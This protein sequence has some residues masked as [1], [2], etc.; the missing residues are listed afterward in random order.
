MKLWYGFGSE[1][2]MRLRMIGKFKEIGDA[3]EAM[4][5]IDEITDLVNKEVDSGEIE[6]D[7]R[8]DRYS[9]AMLDLLD[10]LHISTVSP[11]ELE[12]FAYEISI[13]Q[14]KDEVIITSEESDVS[15]YLKIMI[16]KGARLEVYSAHNYAR[17]LDGR[18]L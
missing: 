2:S 16:D 6:L 10:N 11:R 13:D 14:I 4:R 7:G 1:H 12:Q 9:V 3:S 17:S 8:T 18:E 5:A 15:A